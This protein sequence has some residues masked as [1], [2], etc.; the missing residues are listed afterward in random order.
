MDLSTVFVRM[1]LQEMVHFVKVYCN[2]A[3]IQPTEMLNARKR[4]TKYINSPSKYVMFFLLNVDGCATNETQNC[5]TYATCTNDN[6]SFRCICKNGFSG[7]GTLCEGTVSFSSAPTYVTQMI[8]F[9]KHKTK[10]LSSEA[11]PFLG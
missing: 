3:P 2:S 7:N 9:P 5:H 11:P 10:K 1:G 6:E 4:H 8:S